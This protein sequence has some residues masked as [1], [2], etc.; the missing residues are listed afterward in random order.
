M[1]PLKIE[2]AVEEFDFAV[3]SVPAEVHQ[4]AAAF[5]NP[6]FDAQIHLT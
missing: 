1:L 3:E 5:V 2:F 6:L 4:L